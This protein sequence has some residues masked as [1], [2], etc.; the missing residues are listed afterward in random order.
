MDL[1]SLAPFQE[2]RV[3]KS[4]AEEGKEE[5][6]WDFSIISSLNTGLI[7]LLAVR[8]CHIAHQSAMKRNR[9][10]FRKHLWA[11]LNQV[12]ISV[13]QIIQISLLR[14]GGRLSENAAYVMSI[15]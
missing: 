1:T 15:L 14:S 8:L 4:S 10:T 5:D 2:Q 12:V 6:L 11:L 3:Q 13:K 7:L 9:L